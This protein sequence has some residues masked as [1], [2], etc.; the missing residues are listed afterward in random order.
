M[1]YL[2]GKH[3]G[4]DVFDSSY[5]SIVEILDGTCP[6]LLMRDKIELFNKFSPTE[7]EVIREYIFELISGTLHD[8]LRIFEEN[9]QFKVVY[10][11][12]GEQVD[13]NKISEMLKS[14]PIIEN[15]WIERFSKELNKDQST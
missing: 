12:D 9:E 4:S 1:C 8:F 5:G 11:E 6:N 13:L 14:E 2:V 7:K 3:V 15:G 10:E